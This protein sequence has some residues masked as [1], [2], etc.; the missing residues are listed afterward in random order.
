M[1]NLLSFCA[2]LICLY[3]Y[4]YPHVEPVHV[5][6]QPPA[7]LAPRL[8]LYYHS[9]LDA[10]AMPPGSST[11]SGYHSTLAASRFGAGPQIGSVSN[12]GALTAP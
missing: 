12:F 3:C 10:P 5:A 2:F 11:G 7:A 9:P 1:K 4:L 8:T 6:T